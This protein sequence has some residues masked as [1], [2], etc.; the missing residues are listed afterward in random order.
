MLLIRELPFYLK[1]SVVAGLSVAL[2][3]LALR[4]IDLGGNIPN[5]LLVLFT[6][7]LAYLLLA[8]L[9]KIKEVSETVKT[10]LRR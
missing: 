3:S 9:A 10:V 8:R 7:S 4:F 6:T 5:L 1:I 2:A